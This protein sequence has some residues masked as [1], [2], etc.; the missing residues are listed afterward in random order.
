M[1]DKPELQVQIDNLKAQFIVHR[2]FVLGLIAWLYL[3]AYF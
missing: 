3:K 2:V 1:R